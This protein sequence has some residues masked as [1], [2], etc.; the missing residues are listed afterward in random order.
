MKMIVRNFLLVIAIFLIISICSPLIGHA[1]D[2]DESDLEISSEDRLK[3]G[4]GISFG[5]GGNYGSGGL[6]LSLS[7]G[8]T[9]FPIKYISLGTSIGYGFIP[10]ILSKQ[11]GGTE[12]VFVHFL[13]WEVVAH[14]HPVHFKKW[15]PYFGPGGG[16]TYVWFE[17]ENEDYNSLWYEIFV[18]GGI[19]IWVAKNFGV[20]L[21]LRY[22]I[23]YFEEAWHVENGSFSFG[24]SGIFLF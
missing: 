15:S 21:N 18:E 16:L 23:P 9:Y 1:K 7:V 3:N 24:F 11:S 12:N 17:F 4:V 5:L 8:V 19:T 10:V 20:N 6:G 14:V 22:S 13:P 2:K